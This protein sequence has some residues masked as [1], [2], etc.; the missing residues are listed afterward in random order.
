MALLLP[1]STTKPLTHVRG[2]AVDMLTKYHPF[3]YNSFLS[4]GIGKIIRCFDDKI[5]M[6]HKRSVKMK[7]VLAIVFSCSLLACFMLTACNNKVDNPAE[8]ILQDAEA[9]LKE[10]KE[11]VEADGTLLLNVLAEDK[12]TIIYEYKVARDDV[13]IDVD[14]AKAN[15][16][17]MAAGLKTIVEELETKGAEDA[18]IV[19]RFLD[20]DGGEI[21]SEVIRK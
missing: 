6:F 7:K 3:L 11:A 14:Q 21:Y 15:I 19:I 4:G 18:K 1:I 2:F 9:E 20:K 16:Q 8:A 13:E 10:A 5:T 12:D 17:S